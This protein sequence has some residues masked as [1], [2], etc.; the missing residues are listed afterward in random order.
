MAKQQLAKREVQSSPSLAVS[1]GLNKLASSCLTAD[2][3]KLLGI[4]MLEGPEVFKLSSAFKPL[5]SLKINY[6]GLDGK[7]ISDWPACPPF[8]RLRYLEKPHD[9]SAATESKAPRY[10]QPAETLPVAYFPRS[11][12]WAVIATD[13]TQSIIITE[14]ELKA[15]AACKYGYPTIGLGGVWNF[16]AAKQGIE[17][18][19]SLKAINWVRRP[20]IIAFD[21]DYRTN[22]DVMK[23][24]V[25]LGEE[26]QNRG[27][28]PFVLTLPDVYSD[29]EGEDKGKKTGLDDFLL[30]QPS[31]DVAFDKLQQLIN[32]SEPLGIARPLF[33]YNNKYAYVRNPGIIV[34]QQTL[35][36]AAPN[37]F[38]QH[39][40]STQNYMET[41]LSKEG[42][43]SY[44][45]TS[46]A[47]AWL[48]WPLRQE[49]EILTYAPG[50]PLFTEREHERALNVWPG[51]GCEP[52]KGDVKP[53][54]QLIEHVFTGAEPGV[55]E[56]FL[57]W[58]AY[59][60]Q[61][62]GTKMF[63]S[64]VI[65]GTRHGTGKSLIGYTLGR[66]YGENFT[67][68]SQR[69][70]HGSFNEWA[71][72]K[73]FVMGDD[74]TGSN[75]REDNDLLKKF[76]TQL[77][78][79]INGKYVPT[80]EVPDC[81]NYYF[82]SNHPDAFFLEDDDRRMFLHEV[83][84]GPMSQE[85]YVEYMKWLNDGGAEAVFH[86]MQNM[87]LGN[88][89]PAAPALKT[90]SRE[91]MIDDVK[92]DLGTW[93]QRLL[94]TPDVILRVGEIPV[95]GDIFTNRQL[96]QFYD[97]T[98]STKITANGLGRELRRAGAPMVFNGKPVKWAEGQDRF[99]AVRN[100]AK[101]TQSSYKEIAKHLEQTAITNIKDYRY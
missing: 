46:A 13:S 6:Y 41:V 39:L 44:K 98:G 58:C 21:S 31:T 36:K 52:K 88:F 86:Y 84:V 60:I 75:K 69:D 68:I 66:V 35:F 83:Q 4:E 49:V 30:M 43:T 18:I 1:L 70:L 99:Y 76:I 45:P 32:T 19:D 48:K 37:A 25:M 24:L 95:K 100:A 53:F 2:D 34:N 71:E 81:I 74:V 55:K 8:Y 61:H 17:F 28:Y 89:N 11:V 79:R 9:F 23:A 82:T 51:W 77:K 40:E 47:S 42:D 80:Y 62:P 16:R 12:N 3:A 97:P 91:R 87:K 33:E 85:F 50:E 7:P 5:A 26:L 22:V 92:S 65:Y 15:A 27:A 94:R 14:G 38:A 56:W 63:S 93:V 96:L 72:S 73:Q 64:A 20:V 54:L 101:W 29:A 67:E 59:P 90:V 10:V 78:L 57:Q